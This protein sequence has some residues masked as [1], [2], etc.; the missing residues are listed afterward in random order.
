[1]NFWSSL[2]SARDLTQDSVYTRLAF[3]QLNYIPKA[4]NPQ[5]QH[6]GKAAWVLGV[7]NLQQRGFAY[8][9]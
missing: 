9:D 2:L 6:W 1:M 7:E 4:I 5:L 8:D 3:H